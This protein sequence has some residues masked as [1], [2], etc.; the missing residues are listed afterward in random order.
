MSD[1]GAPSPVGL[2]WMDADSGLPIFIGSI[3]GLAD[4]PVEGDHLDWSDGGPMFV[5][6]RRLVRFNGDGVM[7]VVLLVRKRTT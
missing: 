6:L 3:T 5:V 4:A 1:E 2:S 7:A